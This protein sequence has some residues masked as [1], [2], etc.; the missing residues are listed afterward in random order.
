M[1]W[2]ANP[3]DAFALTGCAYLLAFCGEPTEAIRLLGT[4][5]RYPWG[6]A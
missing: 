6:S 1:A 2:R 4:A 3:Q 5:T